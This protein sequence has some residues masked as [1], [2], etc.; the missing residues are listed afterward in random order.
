MP[1]DAAN[2]LL[3]SLSVGTVVLAILAELSHKTP[4]GFLYSLIRSIICISCII[5]ASLVLMPNHQVTALQ[6]FSIGFV[7]LVSLVRFFYE[8]GSDHSG[9]NAHFHNQPK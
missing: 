9:S 7:F 4:T 2:F 1:N 3:F 8:M 6:F 5:F